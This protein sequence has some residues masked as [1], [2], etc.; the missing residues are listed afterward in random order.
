MSREALVLGDKGFLGRHFAAELRA[1]GYTVTGIDV[2]RADSQDV[3]V[4]LE[5]K[6]ARKDFD[7]VVHAAAVVGGREK[8]DGSPLETA[9]NLEIDAAVFRWAAKQRP[10]RVLYFS[11]SAAYPV[12]W[13]GEQTHRRLSEDDVLLPHT[14]HRPDQV[15]GWSKVIGE[16]LADRLRRAGVGCTVVRP[17]S[18]YGTDQSLDYPFPSFIARALRRDDP[19][20]LWCG[21]CV[22]DFVH[23]D[24]IVG[25]ALAMCDAGEDGP[26]NICTGEAT[27]FTELARVVTRAVGYE[28]ELRELAD[29]PTGVAYRVGDPAAMRRF[30][31]PKVTL[32]DGIRRALEGV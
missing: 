28:P 25:A 26:F 3:R 6:P 13:Q 30:W 7:L 8:I 22:R 23:V 29:K 1:R 21:S 31:E 11:S 2:E 15:Y 20:E 4:W 24:D 19:F 18:G 10:G 14:V 17:F 16:V 5:T 9:V 12:M 32:E 27:S